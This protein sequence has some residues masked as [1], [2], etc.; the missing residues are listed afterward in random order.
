MAFRL[1]IFSSLVRIGG[2]GGFEKLA[3]RG[4]DDSRL[5][6]FPFG[7]RNSEV[8]AGG[9][10]AAAPADAAKKASTEDASF[11]FSWEAS[12][13]ASF[14]SDDFF[15]SSFFAFFFGVVAAESCSSFLD[16]VALADLR[17]SFFAVAV[18]FVSFFE[19]EVVDSLFVVSAFS[20]VL[21]SLAFSE[22]FDSLAVSADIRDEPLSFCLEDSTASFR[23]SDFF[24]F[25]GSSVFC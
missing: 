6:R 16:C 1:A 23:A 8:R 20:A 5:T 9:A 3:D 24:S 7:S 15:L 19:D 18:T 21:D 14:S 17:V 22:V 13:V 11:V 10:N 4:G 12:A 25:S 2:P